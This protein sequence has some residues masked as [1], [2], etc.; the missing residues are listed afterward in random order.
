MA[1]TPLVALTLGDP[2]GI[3]PEVCAKAFGEPEVRAAAR[4]V[5]I[6]P[7]KL[8]CPAFPEVAEVRDA[9]VPEGGAVW[10]S[11]AAPESWEMG[12]A[13]AGC[14]RAALAALRRGHELALAGAVDALVTAPVCKEALHLAG[15][16]VEGQTELLGRWCGVDDHQMLA[17]AGE[18]R[19]LLLS[20]H[21]ALRAALELVTEER[22]VR[23]LA[24]LDRGL[25][26][27][28]I[29][30]PRVA[31]AGLNP[32]AG[33][34]G[35][36]GREELEVLE[37][38]AA[39]ARAEGVNVAGP[40]SPDAVFAA[41]AKG[42]YDGVLALYHDQAF[43]P[44]KLLGEGEGYTV[45]LGLPYLRVS[46]AHGTAFDLAGKGV[47]RHADLAHALVEAARMARAR[48]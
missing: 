25:R 48:R 24:L 38:A 44:I 3:G 27:L 30:E 35:R 39:R 2:A 33:E 14:G 16:P 6:G 13:Q 36:Y 40:V 22:V 7:A 23:H 15:E 18:L 21:L 11:T 41:A 8:R 31:L 29:A 42:A 20:R 28:G 9:D 46:P 17:V 34:G 37:P 26:G 10:M 5:V 19:V 12:R 1:R 32:H 45:L 4:Y 43:I 47:A